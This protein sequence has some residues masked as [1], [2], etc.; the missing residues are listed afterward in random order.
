MPT[1]AGGA[2]WEMRDEASGECCW[3]GVS[4][5]RGKDS[6]G[7]GDAV[8]SVTPQLRGRR[9]SDDSDIALPEGSGSP[10]RAGIQLTYPDVR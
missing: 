3:E 7:G 9:D 10:L 1:Y 2:G 8:N 4:T 5:P 6:H